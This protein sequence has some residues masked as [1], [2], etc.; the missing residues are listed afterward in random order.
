MILISI[1]FLDNDF[2]STFRAEK[3]TIVFMYYIFFIYSHINWH[4]HGFHFSVIVNRAAVNMDTQ[5]SLWCAESVPS[6]SNFSWV[7]FLLH[8][9]MYF[10]Y[11]GVCGLESGLSVAG[12]ELGS[13]VLSAITLTPSYPTRPLINL[14]TSFHN[15]CT[16]LH[17]HYQF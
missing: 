11:G 16:N 1:H 13:S 17:S 7:F 2:I 10:V 8:L 12:I 15:D 4:M 9:F 14:H 5:A 6:G 3:K